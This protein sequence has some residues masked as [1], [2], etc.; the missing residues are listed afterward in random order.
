MEKVDIII[1]RDILHYTLEKL[2]MIDEIGELTVTLSES[3]SP[4]STIKFDSYNT[5]KIEFVIEER[6]SDKIL[7]LLLTDRKIQNGRIDVT[8]LA[9]SLTLGSKDSKHIKIVS[10][11]FIRVPR[12]V[13][14]E[15]ITSYLELQAEIPEYI[16]RLDLINRNDDTIIMEEEFT[17]DGIDL[18]QISKHTT[19]APAVY[20]IEIISG[21]LEG[22]KII[23]TLTEQDNGTQIMIVGEFII[24]KEFEKILGSNP[25]MRIESLIRKVG[26]RI[27]RI[28][29]D[30]FDKKI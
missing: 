25:K 7:H 29:E 19:Y 21:Y 24:T 4:N 9:R 10:S 13:V 20:E 16:S 18:K 12:S 23:I 26:S 15:F 17:V 8:E 27:T 1:P 2:S 6:L 22:S 30:R 5:A 3:I 28:I 11:L 14:Y